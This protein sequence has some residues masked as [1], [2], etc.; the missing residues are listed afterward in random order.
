MA[1]Q[2][3]TPK[4]ERELEEARESAKSM[5]AKD[6]DGKNAEEIVDEV[7]HTQSDSELSPSEW[8]EER[9]EGGEENEKG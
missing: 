7:A 4:D 6:V 5:G 9:E 1:D 8:K 3:D 2:Q